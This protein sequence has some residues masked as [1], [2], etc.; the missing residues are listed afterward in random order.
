MLRL[1]YLSELVRRETCTEARTTHTEAQAAICGAL[2]FGKWMITSSQQSVM[3]WDDGQIS[4]GQQ[5]DGGC[6]EYP[7]VAK[8]IF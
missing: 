5:D 4:M 2:R 7:P 8:G 3:P 1:V 6:S